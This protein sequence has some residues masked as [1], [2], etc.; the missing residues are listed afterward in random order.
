MK[1]KN[2]YKKRIEKKAIFFIRSYIF[3]V[4]YHGE[5]KKVFF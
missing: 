2:R 4:P 3:S 5:E 1:R